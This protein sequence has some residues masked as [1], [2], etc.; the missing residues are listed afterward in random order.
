MTL[1]C[2]FIVSFVI[3]MLIVLKLNLVMFL[4]KIYILLVKLRNEDLHI[5]KVSGL[6][7]FHSGSV[8][9]NLFSKEENLS[10]YTNVSLLYVC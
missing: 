10:Y 1:H 4:L 7:C 3:V 8:S 2:I 9:Q 6:H 5:L